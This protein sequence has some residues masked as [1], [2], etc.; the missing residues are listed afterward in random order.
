MAEERTI[1]NGKICAYCLKETK[2]VDSEII[3]GKSYGPVY[4]CEPCQAWVG[5]H[6]HSKIA[7]GRVANKEL[8]EAKKKAHAAFDPIWQKDMEWNGKKRHEARNDAYAW[9]AEQMG[10][11]KEVCHIGMFDVDQCYQVIL[12]CRGL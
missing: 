2:L 11:S 5:V 9:L 10:I 6:K 7:L 3:Y 4:Y 1:M 12:F 8:R